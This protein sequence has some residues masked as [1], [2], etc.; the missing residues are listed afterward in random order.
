M[1]RCQTE[2]YYRPQASY[3][4]SVLLWL[5]EYWTGPAVRVYP[6]R[7]VIRLEQCRNHRGVVPP[8]GHLRHFPFAQRPEGAAAINL[9]RLAAAVTCAHQID[10][11]K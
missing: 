1:A 7:A 11:A 2:T 3:L 4:R 8:G 6:L 10:E 9:K 5:Q